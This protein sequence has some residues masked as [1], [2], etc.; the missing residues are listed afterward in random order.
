MSDIKAL[1]DHADPSRHPVKRVGPITGIVTIEKT[2]FDDSAKFATIDG[3]HYYG[4]PQE[5]TLGDEF[6]IWEEDSRTMPMSA[7]LLWVL[8][9]SAGY[10]VG[11]H[12]GITREGVALPVTA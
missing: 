9:L 4:V 11:S 6:E 2:R 1:R 8:Q 3:D 5:A 10:P 7:T 12:E